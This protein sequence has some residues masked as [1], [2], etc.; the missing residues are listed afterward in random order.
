[1]IEGEFLPRYHRSLPLDVPGTTIFRSSRP[2]APQFDGKA[3]RVRLGVNDYFRASADA[4]SS[5]ARR[6]RTFEFTRELHPSPATNATTAMPPT[7][8]AA[9]PPRGW[10]PLDSCHEVR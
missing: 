6:F 10:A 5:S 4:E 7:D 2:V 3:R 1:M 8:P 9:A